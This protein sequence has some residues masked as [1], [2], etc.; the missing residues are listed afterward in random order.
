M[1]ACLAVVSAG[2]GH[3]G[4]QSYGDSSSTYAGGYS[5]PYYAPAQ[6]YDTGSS[7]ASI[8]QTGFS[9]TSS[10]RAPAVYYERSFIEERGFGKQGKHGKHGKGGGGHGGHGPPLP[11]MPS[12]PQMGGHGKHGK[13][14][15]V[16][17]HGKHGKHEKRGQEI[18]I[19][20]VV[21]PQPLVTQSEKI[22]KTNYVTKRVHH[23][24]VLHKNI[25]TH[26]KQENVVQSKIMHHMSREEDRMKVVPGQ[27]YFSGVKHIDHTTAKS[28]PPQYY[29]Q[30]ELMSST[31]VAQTQPMQYNPDYQQAQNYQP[32]YEQQIY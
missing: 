18:L 25:R 28:N 22:Y 30:P 11:Q 14:G 6:S 27:T 32:A 9:D 12:F 7:A 16:G 19:E 17:K 24:P 26:I 1:L 13:V 4:Y 15:K 31:S 23:Q 21:H 20:H 8:Y 5:T 2:G 10:S 29:Q 3:G